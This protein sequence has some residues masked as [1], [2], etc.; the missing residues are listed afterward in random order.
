ML[1]GSVLPPSFLVGLA[2]TDRQ[3]P[4]GSHQTRA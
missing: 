1:I 2:A 4:A 3:P